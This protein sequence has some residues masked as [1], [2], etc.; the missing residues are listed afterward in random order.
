PF[1]QDKFNIS[2]RGKWNMSNIIFW[3]HQCTVDY[4]FQVRAKINEVMDKLKEKLPKYEQ[5]FDKILT[6][7]LQEDKTIDVTNHGSKDEAIIRALKDIIDYLLEQFPDDF[8]VQIGGNPAISAIR[9]YWLCQGAETKLPNVHYAGLFPESVK[10][11]LKHFPK[12]LQE[13]FFLKKPIDEV[14]QS[15]GIET[16]T[17]YKLILIYGEGR[18]IQNLAPDANFSEF[19]RQIEGVLRGSD[20]K[21]RAIFAFTMPPLLREQKREEKEKE[22]EYTKKLI[23]Q[24]KKIDSH[25]RLRIFVSTRNIDET[26]MDYAKITY[27]FLTEVEPDIISMNEKEANMIHTA[28][29][30]GRHNDEPLAYKVRDLPIRAMKVCH[31]ASGVIMDLGCIPERIVNSEEFCKDPAKYLEEVLRLSADGATYAMDATAEPLPMG[32]GVSATTSLGRAA[33]ESMIRIYSRYIQPEFRQNEGFKA[34]F[35]NLTQPPPAGMIGIAAANVVRPRGA[36][37]GLGAIFDS[38]LLSFLMRG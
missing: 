25:D 23:Q 29:R 30:G 12:E 27:K 18:L 34:T 3:A 28:S 8:E 33:N 24:L 11:A 32:E 4:N 1:I 6:Q 26:D 5:E 9:G 36:L 31:S 37:V 38:L 7:G 22:I 2:K 13:V 15:I 17:G 19:C 20:S 21:S 16:D 14:P 10:E 35:L